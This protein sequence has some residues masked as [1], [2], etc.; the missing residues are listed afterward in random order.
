MRLG[1]FL[2][3][4]SCKNIMMFLHQAKNFHS[5][6]DVFHN[7]LDIFTLNISVMKLPGDLFK[8]KVFTI[9]LIF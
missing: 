9:N 1:F 2:P 4:I 7:K 3:I 5:K 6:L 8:T